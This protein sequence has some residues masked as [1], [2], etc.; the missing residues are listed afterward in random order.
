MFNVDRLSENV[1][2]GEYP[3]ILEAIEEAKH[4]STQGKMCF[5]SN[6]EYTHVFGL[7]RNGEFISGDDGQ[8]VMKVLNHI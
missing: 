5:V 6:G 4:Q 3:T 2:V 1:H 8:E 7:T